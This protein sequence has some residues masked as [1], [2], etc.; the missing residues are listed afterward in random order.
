MKAITIRQPWAT[1]IALGQKTFETRSW[2]TPYRGLLLI[3]SSA[4]LDDWAR[5]LLLEE[6]F[7]GALTGA[8]LPLGKILCQTRLVAVYRTEQIR[9]LQ[10]EKELAFGDFSNGRFAWLLRDVS[11][12]PQPIPARGQLGLWE[13]RGQ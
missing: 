7:R 4:C 8:D 6:P 9:H 12:L 2:Y 1:L 13:F 10:S 3:H 5:D 11:R